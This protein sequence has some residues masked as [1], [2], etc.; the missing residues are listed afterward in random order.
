MTS[1]EAMWHERRGVGPRAHG[2]GD[3]RGPA[4]RLGSARTNGARCSSAKGGKGMKWTGELTIESADFDPPY[5]E[6]RLHLRSPA[7]LVFGGGATAGVTDCDVSL[8]S[9]EGVEVRCG[10]RYR[11]TVEEVDE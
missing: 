9:A 8:S 7:I 6:A 1:S 10:K 4:P 11:V 3:V 5:G 2:A